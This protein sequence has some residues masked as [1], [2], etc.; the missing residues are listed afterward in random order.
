M[1]QN[2][3]YWCD[4]F[5]ILIN[6]GPRDI[7][8]DHLTQPRAKHSPGLGQGGLKKGLNGLKMTKN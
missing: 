8:N 7:H 4:T 2:E 5:K 1:S 6:T 3:N